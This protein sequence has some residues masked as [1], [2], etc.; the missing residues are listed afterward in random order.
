MRL[1]LADAAHRA[2]EQ[3]SVGTSEEVLTR[4]AMQSFHHNLWQEAQTVLK[5]NVE[6]HPQSALALWNLAYAYA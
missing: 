3:A 4:L 5:R 1:G 2:F 6:L